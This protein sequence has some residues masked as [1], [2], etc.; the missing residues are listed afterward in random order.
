MRC[1]RFFCSARIAKHLVCVLQ[2]RVPVFHA[3]HCKGAVNEVPVLIYIFIGKMITMG[4]QYCQVMLLAA[5]F[6]NFC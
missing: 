6:L 4:N 1:I 3:L 5:Q 2:L